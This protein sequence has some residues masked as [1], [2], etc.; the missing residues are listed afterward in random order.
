MAAV[1]KNE[2]ARIIPDNFLKPQIIAGDAAF[3]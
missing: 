3:G 2:R 1:N